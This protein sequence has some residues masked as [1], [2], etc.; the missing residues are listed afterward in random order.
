MTKWVGVPEVKQALWRVAFALP[1]AGVRVGGHCPVCGAEG[2]H[3][4]YGTP[5][6]RGAAGLWE[7]CAACCSYEHSNSTVPSWWKPVSLPDEGSLT[8][9]PSLVVEQLKAVQRETG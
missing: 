8:A 6:P 4:Y 2:L 7:W 5:N 1:S 3:R 9:E